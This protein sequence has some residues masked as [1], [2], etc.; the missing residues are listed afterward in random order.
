MRRLNII[1]IAAVDMPQGG[2]ESTR[3]K[4]LAAALKLAGHDVQILLENPSGN[5][6]QELLQTSG[7]VLGIPFRYILGNTRSLK[8]SDFFKSKYLAVGQL[9]S[10]IRAEHEEK[11]VDVLWFNQMA[12]HTIYPLTKLAKKLGIKTIHSYEDERINGP[13]IKRKLIHINQVMAD[14]YMS[15]EAD[16]LVV[17]S[18]FLRK[19]YEKLSW[20]K[21]PVNIIP[22]IVEVNKWQA[23]PEHDNDIPVLFYFGGFF[24]FDDIEKMIEAVAI[25]KDQGNPVKLLMAGHNK[26][27]PEYMTAIKQLIK[28]G[29]VEDMVV[30]LGFTMHEKLHEYIQ[31]A[32]VLIGLRK[33][34]EWSHT[35]LSTKL[36]EYL[37][38]GRP[39][40]CT[41]A[42]D[43][44]RYL[45][46]GKSAVM[47]Q[48]GSSAKELAEA[49]NHLATNREYRQKIGEGGRQVALAN[50][51][52]NVVAKKLNDIIAPLFN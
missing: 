33:D 15:K 30:L 50:F 49:I 19:K 28:D 52:I 3:L 21:T 40:I 45:E 2:G 6:K 25:L 38:T 41:T 22:T 37:S 17:I 51:D 39:V 31:Q 1:I 44:T 43:N 23:G 14:R 26:K 5:V 32:N 10:A 46:D 42:G 24:G 29:G 4:T 11:K 7:E 34:D 27:K 12:F 47:L 36:S 48:P 13:G 18:H 8:G 9:K 20:G 16:L 35:G